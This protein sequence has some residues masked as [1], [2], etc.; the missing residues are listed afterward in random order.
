MELKK[1]K[2][3]VGWVFLN[4]DYLSI[5]FCDLPLNRTIWNKSHITISLIRVW[6]VHLE[7]RSLLLKIKKQRITGI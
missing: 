5:L 6:A 4:P 1:Q 2:T 3:Q 7:Y